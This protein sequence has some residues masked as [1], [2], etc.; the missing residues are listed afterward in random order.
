[1]N[2][3][4]ADHEDSQDSTRNDIA[5]CF[6]HEDARTDRCSRDTDQRQKR[7]EVMDSE[8]TS[9]NSKNQQDNP[10][11]D[12]SSFSCSL[13]RLY[14]TVTMGRGQVEFNKNTER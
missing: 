9:G 1:M 2:E 12:E 4:A 3:P 5:S 7:E 11:H 6:C 10:G 14:Y 8:Q 13:D